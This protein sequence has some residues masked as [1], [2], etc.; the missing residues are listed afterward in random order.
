MRLFVE[1][2][3]EFLRRGGVIEQIPQG[4][5]GEWRFNGPLKSR[6]KKQKKL[7]W[8]ARSQR[9]QKEGKE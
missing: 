8:E 1:T 9:L 4:K 6:I 3:E 7:T 2:V 5:S